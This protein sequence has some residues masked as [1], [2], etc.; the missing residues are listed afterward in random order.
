V[1]VYGSYATNDKKV[2]GV[3]VR[4][5]IAPLHTEVFV[6]LLGGIETSNRGSKRTI[7]NI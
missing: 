1:G 2:V 7:N 4:F 6:V 3:F 5:F